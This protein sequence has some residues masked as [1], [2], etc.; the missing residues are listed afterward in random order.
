[1]IL[2]TKKL[3]ILLFTVMSGLALSACNDNSDGSKTVVEN[4]K[5]ELTD[6]MWQDSATSQDGTG[7]ANPMNYAFPDSN[8]TYWSS[9]FTVPE[10][11]K[12]LIEGDYPYARHTSLVSYTSKGERV[13]SLLDAQ[14][15]PNAGS[16]N[17]FIPG[18]NRLSKDRGYKAEL[19]LGDLPATPQENTLY[20]PKTDTNDVALI[21]RIYVPNKG[22][23]AKAGVSFPRF[24][25]QLANGET[26]T[27]SEVC[28]ILKVKKKALDKVLSVP[29]ETSLALYNKQPYVGFPAQQVPTWYTAYNGSANISCIYKYK[30]DQCE[31]FKTE[32]KVNQWATPDNEYTYSVIS[33]KLG[34][35]VVL[36]GKLPQIAPT[37]NNEPILAKGD[38]RYLSICTNELI[39]TATNFCI[40]DEQIK[41]KD[42]GGYYT[43]VVSRPE[44]R[45][46]NAK[47]EC[48][49]SYLP[50]SERG[51]G[52][53]GADAEEKGHTDL[54]FL[55]MRNL[56]PY[57]HFDQ[58]IQNTK[59]WGDEKSVMGDYLPDI[60][61]TSKEDVEALGCQTLN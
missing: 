12:I 18:N 2:K 27:G 44:D 38:L 21:Y 16:V 36:K 56:L 1:M 22:F 3:N 40:Y 14:I 53:T 50:L 24:K 8:V 4:P 5:A 29:L 19:V 43:I 11:A 28:N 46:A 61:Y 60:T 23:N 55:I 33:R 58:A 48:G 32:R 9:E 31:G 57:P 17:P 37:T 47:D 25:V 51:D 41:H 54:G 49:I 15:K 7:G 59:V 13:N 26:K 34:K 30:I 39:S 52:Y 35:V 45:P 42:K 6:C 20:A 10:G